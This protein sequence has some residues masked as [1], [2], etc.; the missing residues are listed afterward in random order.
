MT[1]AALEH[2]VFE[3]ALSA[4]ADGE[5]PDDEVKALQEHLRNCARCR[6]E[7]AV[8]QRIS[9]ALVLEPVPQASLS[10]RRRIGQIGAPAAGVALLKVRRWAVPAA[11]AMLVIGITSAV[12]LR[13]RSGEARTAIA[14]I[15]L[16][17]DALADCR[18]A[19]GRNFPRKA[20][21][22][23]VGQRVSFAVRPL[24][25]RDAELFS[26]WNTTLAGSPAVGL[27]YRWR[28]TVVVQY[29]VAAEL[30]END[31][32]VGGTLRKG[33][34]FSASESGQ[35]IVATVGA[36]IGTILVSDV[37]PEALRGLVL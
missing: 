11:A 31:P 28:G 24:A 12:A 13:S 30:L 27:A 23:A 21:L 34:V 8:H 16:L 19:M 29:S 7:L 32:A 20:D 4:F 9:R 17:R 22:E 10:L 26:T 3:E 35:S 33:R 37:A 15:P 14:A 1:G 2:A 6:R 36:G 25:R 5:L 18:G